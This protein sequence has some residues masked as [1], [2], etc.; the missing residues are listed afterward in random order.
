M[1][2]ELATEFDLQTLEHAAGS[3]RRAL[4]GLP[5]AVEISRPAAEADVRSLVGATVPDQPL[6]PR[7]A[8]PGL[9][10][11]TLLRPDASPA[12]IERL[13]AEAREHG[14]ASVCINPRFVP[15]A[16][17]LLRGTRILV[18][19]VIGFPLGASMT[20]AKAVE[21]ELAIAQGARE[22]DMVIAVGALKGGALDEVGLDIAALV[23][24]GHA[25][26]AVVK[27]ILETALLSAEEQVRA[28][29]LARQAG[30]D[31]VKTSTGYHLPGAVESDV[32]RLRA[33]AAPG[34][35]VKAAGGIRTRADLERMV[36][37]GATRIGT[38]AGVEIMMGY[39]RFFL[40]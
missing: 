36:R 3:V 15:L 28:C 23:A 39:R 24:V 5:P 4:E 6:P 37:A 16:A 19:T 12:E 30:A 31:F 40:G 9:I 10:D 13:C 34:M 18:D 20:L 26:H 17:R 21:G 1:K 29:L 33:L 14:F 8:I 32:R 38:S 2:T 22:L 11:H 35:G 7:E 27:V 25:H